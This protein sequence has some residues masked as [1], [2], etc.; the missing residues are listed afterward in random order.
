MSAVQIASE[1]LTANIALRGAELMQLVDSQGHNLL[2]AGDP[3]WWSG[4]SPLLF[5][6]V[7]KVPNDQL[8]IEGKEFHMPAHG[9]ARRM[10]FTLLEH[11]HSSCVFELRSNLETQQHYPFPFAL[12]LAYRI[13]GRLLKMAA[14]VSNGGTVAMPMSLGYHPA[15]PWPLPYDARRDSYELRFEIEEPAPV[16]RLIGSLLSRDA[17]PSPV[18]RQILHLS[19]DLFENDAI[20]FDALCSR[21]LTYGTRDT[22]MLEVN[23]SDMPHLGVW[24]KPGAPFICIEPWQGH[25]APVDFA[26]EF[27]EKPGVV[28]VPPGRAK[29]YEMSI[30]LLVGEA[31]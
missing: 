1:W 16:R 22:P 4:R 21:S 3:L 11:D 9:F 14:T 30:E 5:P 15:F 26:G 20:I 29:R 2:W 13:S 28:S 8:L 7:G 25:A 19:D 17:Q 23:F 31:R 10:D 27:R 24:S 12:Q 6:I 18:D